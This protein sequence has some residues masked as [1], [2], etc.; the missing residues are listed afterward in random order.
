MK[1]TTIEDIPAMII[2]KHHDL[3]GR[4]VFEQMGTKVTFSRMEKTGRCDPH[5]H[6][7][8]AQ[9]FIVLR[10]E[11]LFKN[12]EGEALVKQGHSVLFD[13]GEAHSI[14]NAAEAGTEY[15]TVTVAKP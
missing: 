2:P 3:L 13:A 14:C 12:A 11:M 6:E 5:I 7:K 4:T 10:G 15:L 1:I 9:L 8:A